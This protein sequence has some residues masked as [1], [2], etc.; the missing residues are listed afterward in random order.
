MR[1]DLLL[2][3]PPYDQVPYAIA[4]HRR[5]LRKRARPAAIQA[6]APRSM[7]WSPHQLMPC[8][9]AGPR[10]PGA[11]AGQ[12]S[13]WPRRPQRSACGEPS[14]SPCRR[15]SLARPR[16]GSRSCVETDCADTEF[17]RTPGST[18]CLTPVLAQSAGVHQ[19]ALLSK[20]WTKL[21]GRSCTV[22]YNNTLEAADKTAAVL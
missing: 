22:C 11:W 14:A 19:E 15:R 13:T 6:S 18:G 12:A 8:C 4:R 7:Q 9:R 3:R 21:G 17:A 16:V 10:A 1:L 20:Q 2:Q 5:V